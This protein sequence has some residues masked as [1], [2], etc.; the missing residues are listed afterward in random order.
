MRNRINRVAI[1]SSNNYS[2]SR[3]AHRAMLEENHSK[4]AKVFMAIS[5]ATTNTPKP[6]NS[7]E[8]FEEDLKS[9]LKE[10]KRKNH[11]KTMQDFKNGESA[12]QYSLLK[13]EL[14]KYGPIGKLVNHGKN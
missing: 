5:T 11:M 3:K 2:S 10:F 9:Q 4:G 8:V 14:N 6:L 13:A 12:K 7:L 1:A